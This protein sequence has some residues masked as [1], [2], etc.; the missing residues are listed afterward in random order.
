MSQEYEHTLADALR[1]LARFERK[2]DRLGLDYSHETGDALAWIED[3]SEQVA[4]FVLQ[5]LATPQAAP[6]SQPAQ[7]GDACPVCGLPMQA[8]LTGNVSCQRCGME[9]ELAS[10][11]AT[12]RYSIDK[13]PDTLD[14]KGDWII[15]P[16]GSLKEI[17][18]YKTYPVA[19]KELNRLR[20]EAEQASQPATGLRYVVRAFYTVKS[21]KGYAVLPENADYESATIDNLPQSRKFFVNGLEAAQ[22][23]A[24]ALNADSTGQ[25]G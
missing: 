5:A 17:G 16:V 25:G 3:N 11:P 4:A 22:A 18:R 23:A 13:E 24:A 14:E 12:G 6:A 10:E 1:I 2:N 21:G 20:R 19:K 7:E 15:R 9:A 8:E